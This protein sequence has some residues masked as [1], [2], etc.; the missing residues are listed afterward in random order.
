MCT[1][2]TRVAVVNRRYTRQQMK[3]RNAEKTRVGGSA[4]C[5]ILAGTAILT[6]AGCYEM[7]SVLKA[8]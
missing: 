2:L 3:P 5:I 1:A 7:Y 4:R 8:P 6:A